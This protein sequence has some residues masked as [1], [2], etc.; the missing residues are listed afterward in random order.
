MHIA[1]GMQCNVD[2][3][4]AGTEQPHAE[5]KTQPSR[6]RRTFGPAPQPEQHSKR[7]DRQGENAEG[8]EAENGDSTGEKA[9]RYG[10]A[11]SL[12]T[13]D[14]DKVDSPDYTV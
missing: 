7:E 9:F 14:G 12:F 8:G 3:T 6:L 11:M 1:I 5:S 13:N 10:E 4:N 2:P